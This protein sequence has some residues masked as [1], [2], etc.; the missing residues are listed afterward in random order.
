MAGSQQNL[1]LVSAAAD[2]DS[3]TAQ[4][5]ASAVEELRSIKSDYTHDYKVWRQE[6]DA[7]PTRLG[8]PPLW[9][10]M[11]QAIERSLTQLIATFGTE[12]AEKP[13]KKVR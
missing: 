5:R 12:Q 2:S 3:S 1:M 11:W 4:R 13:V 7:S 10:G 8:Q 9:P 6:V